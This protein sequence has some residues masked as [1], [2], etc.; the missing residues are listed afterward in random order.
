MKL[1]QK[2]FEFIAAVLRSIP[3]RED[4]EIVVRTFA[5]KLAETNPKFKRETFIKLATA[6]L[7]K[8]EYKYETYY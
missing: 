3:F 4:H 8:G 2:H 1:T 7:E 6:Q 5:N